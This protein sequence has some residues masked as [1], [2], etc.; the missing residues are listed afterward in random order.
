MKDMAERLHQPGDISISPFPGGYLIG[1]IL[2][3]TKDARLWDYI[4]ATPNQQ[5]AFRL[6]CEHARGHKVWFCEGPGSEVV[7]CD[8][9]SQA[10]DARNAMGA[11]G[12]S[13]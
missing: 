4:A 3:P 5:V 2:D 10:S 11:K 8:A 9:I 6:A 7:D 13:S 1:R 12:S